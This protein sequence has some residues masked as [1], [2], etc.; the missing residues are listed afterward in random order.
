M[1]HPI[2]SGCLSIA[3]T[4]GRFGTVFS[5][6]DG[7]PVR[8]MCLWRRGRGRAPSQAWTGTSSFKLRDPSSVAA[9][10]GGGESDGLKGLQGSHLKKI[11]KFRRRL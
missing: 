8:T 11:A 10:G 5:N 7:D 4:L 3:S 1:P 2:E 9:A 6:L